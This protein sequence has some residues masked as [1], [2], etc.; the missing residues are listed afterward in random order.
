MRHGRR[1]GSPGLHRNSYAFQAA[2]SSGTASVVPSKTISLRSRPTV[3]NAPYVLTRSNGL[4]DV[5]ITWSVENMLLTGARL[6]PATS[7]HSPQTTTRCAR[8]GGSA[9]P[10]AKRAPSMRRRE[11]SGGESSKHAMMGTIVSQ[12]RKARLPLKMRRQLEGRG[13]A[14]A[15]TLD[16]TRR[17]AKSEEREDDLAQVVEEDAEVLDDVR[18]RVEEG[19]QRVGDR[20]RLVVPVEAGEI[21]PARVAAE[22][23]EPRAEHDP[24]DESHRYSQRTGARAGRSG[25]MG[26]GSSGAQRKM[27]E[28]AGLAELDLPSVAVPDLPHMDDRQ[29]QR[30]GIAITIALAN[31]RTTRKDSP[32]PT[33]ARTRSSRSDTPVQ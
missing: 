7:A 26:R 5:F 6:R 8:G 10:A 21:P 3:P 9:G 1:S 17:R 12:L 32:A 16:A 14:Q 20:L 31:P 22:L 30:P 4:N 25:G 13:A 19:T 33:H 24:E 29:V 11:R 28:D 18:K 23:D 27:R 2:C 15:A